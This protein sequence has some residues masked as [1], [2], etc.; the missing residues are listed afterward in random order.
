MLF[1][2]CVNLLPGA[3]DRAGIA[4]AGELARMGYDYIE[5]PLN[6]MMKLEEREFREVE[7]ALQEIALP[8]RSCNDF[9]PTSYQITGTQ[10]TPQAEL[11][12]YLSRAFARME[13]L[14]AMCAVFGS[15]WSRSCPE[16]F[17][18]ERAW[19]QIARFLHRAGELAAERGVTIAIEH[20]N[21]TETNMLNRFAEGVAMARAV[22]HPNV[23][24]LCDYYHL[25]VEGDSPRALL[26]GG[27]LLVH[28]HIAKLEGRRYFTDLEGERPVLEEYAQVLRK[29]GYEG[30]VSIEARVDSRESWRE[31]ARRSLAV[32]RR[33]LQ[34]S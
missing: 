12:G 34:E 3:E 24:A 14:G 18:R 22:D 21:R 33:T 16:G 7:Q 31:D 29:I 28:T 5:L 20:N 26:D 13:E 17:S 1:G 15:P 8:C 25:R 32:L 11:E 30:G 23:R 19:D 2:C 27:A 6:R 10:V 4:Y 9:M